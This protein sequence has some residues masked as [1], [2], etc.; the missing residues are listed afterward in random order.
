MN[1]KLRNVYQGLVSVALNHESKLNNW[2]VSPFFKIM[3]AYSEFRPFREVNNQNQTIRFN[4]SKVD[5]ITNSLGLKLNQTYTFSNS[6]I[7]P[8]L[9]FE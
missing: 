9:Q 5:T 8:F 2:H 4:E 1:V 3:A 7:T 6:L